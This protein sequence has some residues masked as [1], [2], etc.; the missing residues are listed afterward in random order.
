MGEGSAK[1]G[2]RK[3]FVGG[4]NRT[5][6]DDVF[7]G[8]FEK[9]GT[10]IDFVIVKDSNTKK[11]K[12]FGF[13]TY[14]S[15]QGADNAL[16]SRPHTLDG[17]EIDIKRAIPRE[18]NTDTA[19]QRT[20]KVFIGGL[21]PTATENDIK[22]YFNQTYPGKGTVEKCDLIK[23]KA[24]GMS[25]GFAFLEMSSEDFTDLIIID[26]SRPSICG[27]KVEIKKAEERKGRKNF[28][29]HRYYLSFY[30]S[31]LLTVDCLVTTLLGKNCHFTHSYSAASIVL[32]Y[33]FM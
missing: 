15:L 21:P 25:K 18:Q 24:T 1:E 19:H 12:G 23:N 28:L 32:S 6:T 33:P 29:K 8:Y 22:E 26:N 5:T 9:F 16:S 30:L 7:K 17:W 13:V 27:K 11:S 31:F 2:L 20:K 4:L 14:E 10:V 3:I